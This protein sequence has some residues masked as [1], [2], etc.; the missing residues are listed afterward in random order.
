MGEG[1]VLEKMRV[2]KELG[3]LV[4]YTQSVIVVKLEHRIR[5]AGTALIWEE[6]RRRELLRLLVIHF[7]Y[8]SGQRETDWC[9][10][11]CLFVVIVW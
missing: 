7:A 1:A 6:T 8:M 11:V 5:R 10:Y 3:V 9:M 4:F 2:S